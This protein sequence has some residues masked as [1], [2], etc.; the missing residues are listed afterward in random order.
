MS[1]GER[2]AYDI[3]AV[4][5]GEGRVLVVAADGMLLDLLRSTLGLAGYDVEHEASGRAAVAR[6]RSHPF[7]LVVVD[8]ALPGLVHV[9]RQTLQ[10]RGAA[11]L[12]LVSPERFETVVDEVGFSGDD[13]LST[14][15]RVSDLLART[16]ILVRAG[17]ARTRRPTL[18][19]GELLL[20]DASYRAWRAGR[21]LDL[22]PAE[23]RLLRELARNAGAVL[24]KDQI[25]HRVWGDERDDNAIERL[26]SRLRRKVDRDPP[27][28]IRTQR[29]FGYSL[30]V[31]D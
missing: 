19:C 22:S 24:S 6:L 16:H 2:G 29:G 4:V 23:Y 30:S 11:V 18:V 14:P 3:R 15:F 1:A 26:M 28:L 7:D 12:F 17:A 8:T 21:E 31:G 20:D 10:E 9:E 27:S 13:Y 5:R 25:A